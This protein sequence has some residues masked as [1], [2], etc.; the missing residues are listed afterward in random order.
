MTNPVSYSIVLGFFSG[1]KAAGREV[2][3]SSLSKAEVKNK[4][5]FTSAPLHSFVE[6]KG[7][8]LPII[9]S[10]IVTHCFCF[11]CVTSWGETADVRNRGMQAYSMET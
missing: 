6:W 5:C 2:N 3:T 9:V 7:K 10:G 8:T 1:D 11:P 4:W